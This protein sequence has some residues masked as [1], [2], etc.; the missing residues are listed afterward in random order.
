MKKLFTKKQG[1]EHDFWMSYTDL[2][3]AFLIVFIIA[4]ICFFQKYLEKERLVTA[5]EMELQQK[6]EQMSL[7]LD[8]LRQRNR[9]LQ[10]FSDETLQQMLSLYAERKDLVNLNTAFNEVF[11]NISGCTI[12]TVSQSIRFY[13]TDGE[14][15]I[16]TFTGSYDESAARIQ[17]NFK[18][19]LDKFGR[20]LIQRAMMLSKSY[21]I[22]E[23]RIEG[24]CD[25][26]GD[27][28][29]NMKLSSLRA[30]SV[31][32]YIYN[33]C[34]L[35]ADEKLFMK[36]H[37]IAVGYSY[38]KPL[39]SNGEVLSVTNLQTRGF[40]EDKDKSRRVEFRIISKGRLDN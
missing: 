10:S 32:S 26:R 8:T 19:R 11:A 16:F 30:K 18:K 21:D 38:A 35:T 24:H 15:D 7:E 34:Q 40:N 20:K 29:D 23:V 39:N 25:S 13:P 1:D 37:F 4:S 2:M 5:K 33:N 9:R 17:P 14:D 31:Y 3:S 12:D 6:T 36:S 22:Q 27:F 28:I